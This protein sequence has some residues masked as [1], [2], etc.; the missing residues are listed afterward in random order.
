MIVAFGGIMY[1]FMIRPQQK[2]AKAHAALLDSIAED[3][4]VLLTSGIFG[5]VRHTGER[6][7]IVE[8]APGVEVTVLKGNV[9]RVVAPSD[10]EFVF[11]DDLPADEVEA[12][13]DDQPTDLDRFDEIAANFERDEASAAEP[14]AQSEIVAE[15]R[16]DEGTSAQSTDTNK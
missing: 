7:L 5:T 11:T 9:A 1:F 6:Q 16:D 2:R 14:E 10:E 4:R 8:L 12:A 3:T 15:S 13:A